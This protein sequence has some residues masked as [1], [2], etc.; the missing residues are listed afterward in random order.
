V[1]VV[2]KTINAQ[3]MSFRGLSSTKDSQRCFGTR[4]SSM[5]ALMLISLMSVSRGN[6]CAGPAALQVVT[7]SLA[8]R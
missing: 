6:C 5:R 4:V 3:N 1:A 2:F 7:L 8:R